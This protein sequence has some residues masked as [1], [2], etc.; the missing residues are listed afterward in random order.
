[1]STTVTKS[2]GSSDPE[3]KD[4]F[5]WLMQVRSRGSKIEVK[6]DGV[7]ANETDVPRPN[8][9]MAQVGSWIPIEDSMLEITTVSQPIPKGQN[10]CMFSLH[11]DKRACSVKLRGVY[12]T[13]R[14]AEKRK[15]EMN[16][17]QVVWPAVI[18]KADDW[19]EVK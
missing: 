1:M 6:F 5:F 3:I 7:Y 8:T 10:W 18:V 15:K 2:Y 4:Q 12:K 16:G 11:R 19:V 9:I 17:R 14:K 13:L